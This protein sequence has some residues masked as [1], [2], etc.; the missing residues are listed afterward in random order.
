MCAWGISRR[1]ISNN[2]SNSNAESNK[3]ETTLFCFWNRHC[4]ISYRCVRAKNWNC[5]Q[6][7]WD[8]RS[9]DHSQSGLSKF[10]VY[11][12]T[13]IDDWLITFVLILINCHHREIRAHFANID[14]A[15]II[16]IN[17]LILYDLIAGWMIEYITNNNSGGGGDNTMVTK[18]LKYRD[19]DKWYN[20]LSEI[21]EWINCC[22]CK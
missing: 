14:L 16:I 9:F 6:W 17:I 18:Q 4:R 12:H 2:V 7:W 20:F 1:P 13:T 15:P 5:T 3:A 21:N 10:R 19:T 11:I 22:C 8:F